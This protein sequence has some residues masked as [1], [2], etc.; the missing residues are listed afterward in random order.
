V[1][2]LGRDFAFHQ[3]AADDL[4]GGGMILLHAGAFIATGDATDGERALGGGVNFS[5]RAEQRR[6]HEHA[7]L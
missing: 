5:V 2:D 4:R 1:G 3:A 6:L 7:A